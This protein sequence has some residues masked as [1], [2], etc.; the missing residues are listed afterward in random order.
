MTYPRAHLVDFIN[1]GF[2]HCTSRCVRRAWLCGEDTVT[3]QSFEHRKQWIEDRVLKL[4]TIFS[5]DLY[6]YAVMSNHY[7]VVVHLQPQGVYAW[8]DDQVAERWTQ[9]SSNDDLDVR[10]KAKAALLADR[11]RLT[12]ARTRLGSLSWFMRY[13][14]EPLARRANCEDEC[15]GSFWQGRFRS[16]ALLDE[17]AVSACMAYVDMN[18]V[19]ANITGSIKGAPYTSIEYRHHESLPELAPLSAVGTTLEDYTILLESTAG[20]ELAGEARQSKLAL[21]PVQRADSQWHEAVGLNRR[22]YRAY[23]AAHRIRRYAQSL[24]QHWLKG[25]AARPPS[26]T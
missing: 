9:L 12:N 23:G 10:A 1:G 19:R 6:A 20:L 11:E 4:S 8:S 13:I 3:G 16:A 2:Y 26:L 5:V 15:T 22:K 21:T 17:F 24:G 18:P 25:Y 14:N 7:H